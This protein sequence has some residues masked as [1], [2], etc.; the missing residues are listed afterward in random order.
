[1]FTGKKDGIGNGGK[2][3]C[4]QSNVVGLCEWGYETLT[5]AVCAEAAEDLFPKT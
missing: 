1:M 2:P 3:L 4:V 5:T